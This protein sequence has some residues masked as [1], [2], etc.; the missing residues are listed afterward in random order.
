L[1][2]ALGVTVKGE[3]FRLAD[4]GARGSRVE[5]KYRLETPAFSDFGALL[6]ENDRSLHPRP[7]VH[8]RSRAKI[9]VPTRAVSNPRN[10]LRG[11][12]ASEII[13]SQSV[14]TT[15]RS[16]DRQHHAMVGT[17]NHPREMRRNN[18]G[19]EKHDEPTQTTNI[20]PRSLR[21]DFTE[22]TEIETP[23]RPMENPEGIASASRLQSTR[24]EFRPSCSSEHSSTRHRIRPLHSSD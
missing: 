24:F 8:Q 1:V 7:R 23:A 3:V 15:D 11:H 22:R 5:E 17:T 2:S 10:F 21:I 4:E 9:G 20:D 6:A 16:R 19:D 12:C 13:H 18:V 14:D